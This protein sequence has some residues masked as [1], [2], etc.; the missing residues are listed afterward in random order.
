MLNWKSLHLRAQELLLFPSTKIFHKG[1]CTAFHVK[2]VEKSITEALKKKG[3]SFIEILSPCPT[4]YG[5][6]NREGS[7]LDTMKY[8]RENSVIKHNANTKDTD[9]EIGRKITVGRF[10]DKKQ[11]TYIDRMD[12]RLS[13]ILGPRYV[14]FRGE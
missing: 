2:Q 5:R 1:P 9:I 12:E 11:P 8:Y 4:L 10:V 7:G 14:K 13:K 3:F 6:R